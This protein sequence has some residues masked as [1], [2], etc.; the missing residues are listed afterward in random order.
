[1][2]DI[3]VKDPDRPLHELLGSRMQ[4]ARLDAGYTQE[5]LAQKLGVTPITLSRWETGARYPSFEM[6]ERFAEAVDKPLPFFFER[7]PR[8][9][10]ALQALFRMANE[11]RDEQLEEILEYIRLRRRRWYNEQFDKERD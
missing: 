1:M 10:E 8:E 9:S 4:Q 5:E 2:T 7:E 6:L 3:R 11:L